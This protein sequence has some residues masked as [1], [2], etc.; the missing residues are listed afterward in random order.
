MQTMPIILIL[1]LSLCTLSIGSNLPASPAEFV[2]IYSRIAVT[3]M[4]RSR[5]PASITLA[6][7]ILESMF[8]TSELARNSNNFF[9]IKCKKTWAGPTYYI[10]DDDLDS[11]G[12]LMKSCFRAY[13][14][15]EESFIDHSDFLMNN[16]NYQS[17]F[18]YHH[19]DYVN[20]AH[21]LQRCGYAT[22]P[23]Y[24]KKLISTIER[25]DL[26][27]YDAQGAIV[28]DFIPMPGTDNDLFWAFDD[29][30]PLMPPVYEIPLDYQPETTGN[31]TYGL[32]Q[33][34]GIAAFH[35]SDALSVQPSQPTTTSSGIPEADIVMPDPVWI[36]D[37]EFLFE[38]G[39]Q[40]V[41]EF[42]TRGI[43]PQVP[44]DRQ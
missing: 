40:E 1:F 21:G 44:A 14:S 20:W 33:D 39:P 22:N 25:Y 17:L 4:E 5:I 42:Q 28:P 7:G 41:S 38:L 15:P 23:A 32:P 11:A 30:E 34:E 6:Q 18:E 16:A 36:G 24:A 19:T 29:R 37:D 27:I 3:E 8:G 10:E 31:L 26:A 35:V 9:G 12:N 2:Q 43:A 13:G